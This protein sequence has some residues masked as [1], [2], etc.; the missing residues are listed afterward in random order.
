MAFR[1]T[2]RALGALMKERNDVQPA[3]RKVWKAH[4]HTNGLVSFVG[5]VLR[6]TH[7]TGSCWSAALL[8]QVL[9][10]LEERLNLCAVFDCMPVLS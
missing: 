9:S 3:L 7:L 8:R 5:I 6:F 10:S 4:E 1:M 2:G